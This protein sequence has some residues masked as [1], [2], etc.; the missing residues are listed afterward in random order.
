MIF[1]MKD[2]VYVISCPLGLVKLGVASNLRVPETR[3]GLSDRT[4]ARSSGDDLMLLL[5]V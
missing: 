2:Y 1:L 3:F 5:A 4:L